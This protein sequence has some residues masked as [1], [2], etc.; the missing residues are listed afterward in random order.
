MRAWLACAFAAA[1]MC[2]G[3]AH[4]QDTFRAAP[5]LGGLRLDLD[6]QDG[7]YS[8]LAFGETCGLNAIRAT[9]NVPR[10]GQHERWAPSANIF[11]R[12]GED[13]VALKFVSLTRRPPLRLA[14]TRRVDEVQSEE[15]FTRALWVSEKL[16]VAID[17]TPE[18]E[19][20]VR[21]D[22][23]TRSASLPGGVREI[24]FLN[25]TGEAAFIPL[26]IGRTDA[27]VRECTPNP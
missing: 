20:R 9:I 14:L 16:E 18:G 7:H 27:P 5:V 19:V 10:F 21:L 13:Y 25:S 11:L 12:N 22:G 24:A 1:M 8:E 4:A 2:M 17:W 6:T 23:E 26:R 3:A 15:P